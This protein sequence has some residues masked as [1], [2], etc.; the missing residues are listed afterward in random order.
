M[1]QSGLGHGLWTE[2]RLLA[3][4]ELELRPEEIAKLLLRF[5]HSNL[6]QHSAVV[7]HGAQWDEHGRAEGGM[8]VVALA[9]V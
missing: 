6:K 7:L 2:D 3:A 4:A 5:D 8:T 1:E 9:P